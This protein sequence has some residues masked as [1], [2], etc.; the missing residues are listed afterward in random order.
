[1]NV[2]ASA[3]Q[4]QITETA[5]RLRTF[6]KILEAGEQQSGAAALGS[7]SLIRLQHVRSSDIINSWRKLM[8]LTEEQN[9]AEDGSLRV[10]KG[11]TSRQVLVTG[12]PHRVKE[13]TELVQLLD[14]APGQGNALDIPQ[15]EVYPVTDADPASVLSV[16]QLSLI[17]I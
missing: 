4:L 15:L 9:V 1:M 5:G 7:A 8:G 16:M 6:R 13:F 10:A 12:Q 2:L 11:K 17:H 14:V 3:N